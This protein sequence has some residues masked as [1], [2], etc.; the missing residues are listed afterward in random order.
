MSLFETI[1]SICGILLGAAH[2]PQAFRLLKTK[3][4][5]AVSLLTYSIFAFA[6]W[7]WLAYGIVIDELPI[8]LSFSIG[9][10][11]ATWF[12]YLAIKLRK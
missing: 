6:G 5:T 10:T 8:I 1:V 4:S 3:D 9:A 2:Y 11:G 12:L 7:V